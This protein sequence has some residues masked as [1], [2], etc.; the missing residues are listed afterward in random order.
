MNVEFL[1][2]N[3]ENTMGVQPLVIRA[4]SFF[5][6]FVIRHSSFTNVALFYRFT[7][8]MSNARRIALPA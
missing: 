2:T 1:M 5:T 8:A 7:P 4:S 6:T 3:V